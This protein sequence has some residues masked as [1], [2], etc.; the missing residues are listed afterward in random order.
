MF[1]QNCGK[2]LEEGSRFC[3]Y[4]GAKNGPEP[5]QEKQQQQQQNAPVKK[6][7]RSRKRRDP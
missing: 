1:C 5:E 6:E 7:K 2:Q 4:C 3:P